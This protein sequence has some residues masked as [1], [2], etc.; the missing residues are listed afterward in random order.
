MDTVLFIPQVPLEAP[1]VEPE[2]AT[3]PQ[4]KKAKIVYLQNELPT[5]AGRRAI[6]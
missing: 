1:P 3:K 5:Y 2:L 4:S 6:E